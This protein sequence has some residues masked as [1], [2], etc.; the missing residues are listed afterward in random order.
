MEKIEESRNKK[1]HQENPKP[2]PN[3]NLKQ[4][5]QHRRKA[6]VWDCGSTLYDSFELKSFERQLCS[7]IHSRTLSMPHLPDR[8]VAAAADT[9]IPPPS[10]PPVTKKPSKISR[11]LNKLL[12]SVFKSR[13]NSTGLFRFRDRP[14][15]EYCAVYDKSGA[16]STIPEVPEI[17]FGGFSPEINSLVRRSGSERFT[18]TSVMGISCA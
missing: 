1:T 17:D 8:K 7:A 15:D 3:L 18:A 12:K 16:L 6:F 13:Q 4:E 14:G 11:S 2:T 10:L 5:Q 9:M